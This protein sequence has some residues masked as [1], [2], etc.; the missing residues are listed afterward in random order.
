VATASFAFV[1]APACGRFQVCAVAHKLPRV[2]ALFP[3][4]LAG[5]R[6][7]SAQTSIGRRN[8]AIANPD[9]CG[10]EFGSAR[11]LVSRVECPA[12]FEPSRM[13]STEGDRHDAIKR[14]R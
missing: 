4:L 2:Q 10:Q 9:P 1:A 3:D 11:Y 5:V 7:R 13:G 12:R 8:H 14:S 6:Q